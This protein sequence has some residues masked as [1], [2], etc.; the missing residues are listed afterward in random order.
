[1]KT[2][3]AEAKENQ[4]RD[5]KGVLQMETAEVA[6]VGTSALLNLLLSWAVPKY[7]LFAQLPQDGSPSPFSFLL[8]NVSNNYSTFSNANCTF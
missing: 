4:F 2:E 3:L 1:M 7:H 6:I 5:Q 8:A